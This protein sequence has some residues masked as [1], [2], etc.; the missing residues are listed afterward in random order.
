MK[1]F[2]QIDS[3]LVCCGPPLHLHTLC[4]ADCGGIGNNMWHWQRLVFHHSYDNRQ[5]VKVAIGKCWF[6]PRQFLE[7]KPVVEVESSDNSIK[8][9]LTYGQ[10]GYRNAKG[11]QTNQ[12]AT[13]KKL[14]IM[15]IKGLRA[16][17][18]LSAH[19]VEQREFI[20]SNSDLSYKFAE[21]K[22][23]QTYHQIRVFSQT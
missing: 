8:L 15:Q 3:C 23:Q 22:C 1:T 5:D 10:V 21:F 2:I 12:I 13:F 18:R 7:Y 6:W 17:A 11:Q 16:C 19:I 4:K 14:Q 20:V 9:D